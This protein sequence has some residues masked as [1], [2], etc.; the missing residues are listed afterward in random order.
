[1]S[2]KNLKPSKKSRYRQGYY[3]ISKS[4]KYRGEP[5]CIYRSG[6]ELQVFD[7]IENA[8]DIVGWESEPR[9]ITIPYHYE[10]KHRKYY[11][12]AKYEKTDGSIWLVEIKPWQQVQK[13]HPNYPQILAKS[14][15]A[16]QYCKEHNFEFLILTEHFFKQGKRL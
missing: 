5:P 4:T 12:D 9:D 6:L 1:M 8:E 13:S 11:I 15:A 14:K 16:H 2:I 7:M 3:D 10:G